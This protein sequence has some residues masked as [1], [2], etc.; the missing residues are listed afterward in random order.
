MDSISLIL[1]P[2]LMVLNLGLRVRYSG[3]YQI[4]KSEHVVGAS[5]PGARQSITGTK[6]DTGGFAAVWQLLASSLDQAASGEHLFSF[7]SVFC[8]L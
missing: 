2:G 4:W 8:F 6:H 1:G 7:S 5:E 3:F